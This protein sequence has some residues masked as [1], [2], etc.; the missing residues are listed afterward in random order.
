M[1]IGGFSLTSTLSQ[2]RELL[3]FAVDFGEDFDAFPELLEIK[4]LIARLETDMATGKEKY[5]L[6]RAGASASQALRIHRRSTNTWN[7]E[8]PAEHQDLILSA[9]EKPSPA[10]TERENIYQEAAAT[11]LASTPKATHTYAKQLVREENKRLARDPHHAFAQRRFQLRDQDE[12][13]GC[14]FSGYA[15]AAHAALLKAPM[16]DAWR[17]E[18]AEEDEAKDD[19]R[20]IAQRH[21]DNFFQVLRWA[22][23]T[24]QDTTGHC[25]LVIGVKE[26]DE[27]NWRASFGSNV[28]I[29]LTL[30]DLSLLDGHRIIDYIVVHDQDG[31][32]KSLVTCSRS[33]TFN[34]RLAMFSR[35]GC[36]AYPGC[37]EPL[38]RCEAHHVL[39]WARGGPTAI[40]NLAPLCRKHH[41]WNDDSYLEAHIRMSL[42]GIPMHVD[43]YG[44]YTRNNSARARN[45]NGR[46]VAR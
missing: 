6:E 33:A 20:T 25:S 42:S 8:V 35:D 12:H 4:E 21:A 28:G 7:K 36:C 43:K 14:S 37:D 41:C 30:Y 15:P 34:Q 40:D 9:L 17:C 3:Q 44:N 18:K 5:E 45:S 16:D 38:S 46:H 10:S 1:N 39:P 31:A 23:G 27:F 22:S 11:A 13:G 32:V 24:R 2:V 19:N 29:D 26:T